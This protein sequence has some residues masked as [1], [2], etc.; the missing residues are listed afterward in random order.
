MSNLDRAS[1]LFWLML[2]VA[3]IVQSLR[4]GIGTPAN[5]KI[6]FMPFGAATAMAIL[7]LILL[8]RAAKR[9][10]RS[11]EVYPFSGLRVWR[12]AGF[13]VCLVLYIVLLPALG[14]IIATFLLMLA[15]LAL[16]KRPKWWVLVV[17]PGLSSIVSYYIFAR[18]FKCPFPE[19][20]LR[21]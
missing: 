18:V 15:L 11:E 4:M 19:G 8:V 2:S 14:Y 1:G 17:F 13:V 21:F 3:V 10:E 12:I 5:P 7:S 20:L 9:K 16:L 6:G